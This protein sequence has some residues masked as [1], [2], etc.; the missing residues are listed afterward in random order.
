[1]ISANAGKAPS[2]RLRLC[3]LDTY[4]LPYDQYD[5]MSRQQPIHHRFGWH[6][7]NIRDQLWNT[8]RENWYL[9][10]TSFGGPPTHFKI[11]SHKY[12]GPPIRPCYTD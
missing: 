4:P 8:L 2:T 11:V 7:D 12:P 9:G 3:F 5:E 1:M 10:F 6:L